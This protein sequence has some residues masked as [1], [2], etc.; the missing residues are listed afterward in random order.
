MSS[1]IA[2]L[3]LRAPRSWISSVIVAALMCVGVALLPT[4]AG[5]AHAERALWCATLILPFVLGRAALFAVLPVLGSPIMWVVPSVHTVLRRGSAW[6]G[7]LVSLAFAIAHWSVEGLPSG[8]DAFAVALIAYSSWM[9]AQWVAE[10]WPRRGVAVLSWLPA[11]MLILITLLLIAPAGFVGSVGGAQS[12][13]AAAALLMAAALLAFAARRV[14]NVSAMLRARR[15]LNAVLSG[16]GASIPLSLLDDRSGDANLEVFRIHR[17]GGSTIGWMRALF[18]AGIGDRRRAWVAE[19]LG[20]SLVLAFVI[21][22]TASFMPAIAIAL[23]SVKVWSALRVRSWSLCVGVFHP[24]PRLT[25]A[26]VAFWS[27]GA[28][29]AIR[30]GLLLCL[31]TIFDRVLPPLT[32]VTGFPLGARLVPSANATPV[33]IALTLGVF[34]AIGL[35][36]QAAPAHAKAALGGRSRGRVGGPYAKYWM[37]L[38]LPL[39][40]AFAFAHWA[41]AAIVGREATAVIALLVG[42]YALFWVALR[43]SSLTVDLV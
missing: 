43:R 16:S 29:G 27:Y 21:E 34:V 5:S 23:A 7:A 2:M 9:L 3:R 25:R 32:P 11:V 35:I 30:A 17:V 15:A 24:V 31:I 14:P 36:T 4:P 12:L 28:A 20:E 13:A 22:R 18:F 26:A 37:G 40:G 8:I 33:M 39:A 6:L 19:M 10:R 41:S 1:L 42:A 38:S